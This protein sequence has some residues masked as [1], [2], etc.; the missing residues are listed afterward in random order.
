[1]RPFFPPVRGV[2]PHA[3]ECQRRFSRSPVY[4][5]PAPGDP[6]HLVVLGQSGLPY[7]QE[8]AFPMPALEVGV[9]GTG[10]A[11]LLGQRLPLT[12]GPKHIHNRRE[13]LPRWHRLAARSGLALVLAAPRP[14]AR[15]NQR[16]DLASQRFRHRPRLDL[17][18]LDRYLRPHSPRA[19]KDNSSQVST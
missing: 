15:W 17:R 2:G 10:A 8:K 16:F 3:L 14:F 19:N 5:L 4:A 13:N 18:H 12:S 9:H 6:L 11:V 1:M 7:L